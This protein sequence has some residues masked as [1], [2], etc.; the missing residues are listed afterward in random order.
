MGN[1]PRGTMCCENSIQMQFGL[2]CLKKFDIVFQGI[3]YC[4]RVAVIKYVPEYRISNILK[5]P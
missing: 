3:Y 4:S 2:F 1:F 5:M